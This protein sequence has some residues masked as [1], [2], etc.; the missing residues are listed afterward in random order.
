MSEVALRLGFLA[1]KAEQYAQFPSIRKMSEDWHQIALI[2]ASGYNQLAALSDTGEGTEVREQA[3]NVHLHGG[4]DIGCS[5]PACR[6]GRTGL[7][8]LGGQ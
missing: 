5:C 7:D 3:V 2:A 6:H 4:A 1:L 8:A